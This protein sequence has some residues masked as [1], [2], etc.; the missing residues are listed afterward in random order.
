V[1]ETGKNSENRVVAE[2]LG[3]YLSLIVNDEPLV[4]WKVE[5]IGSGWVSMMIGTRE[6]GE[7]EVFYDNLIIWGPL[8]E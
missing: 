5:G 4:S 6:A 1:I 2:C 8:V 3:D 7:L